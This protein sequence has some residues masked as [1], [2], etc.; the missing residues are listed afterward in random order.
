MSLDFFGSFSYEPAGVS[1]WVYL[2]AGLRALH[3]PFSE[4][5]VIV[6]DYGITAEPRYVVWLLGPNTIIAL[7]FT[8]LK[9]THAGLR[10]G[11]RSA[12]FLLGDPG[13]VYCHTWTLW[14]KQPYS[15]E[16]NSAWVGLRTRLYVQL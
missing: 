1:R 11:P 8:T 16:S 13:Y 4:G 14:D 15:K 9:T 3:Q 12:P 5:P 7:G 10:F 2:H 6:L